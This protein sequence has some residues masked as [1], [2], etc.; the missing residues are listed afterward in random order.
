[1]LELLFTGLGGAFLAGSIVL[2]IF[3]DLR[4]ANAASPRAGPLRRGS[5]PTPG[6]GGRHLT[7]VG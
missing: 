4:E 3:V 7:L 1:M 6:S 5:P 2:A